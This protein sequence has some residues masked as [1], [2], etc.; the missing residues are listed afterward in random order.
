M[1]KKGFLFIV[2][3][4]CFFI[5]GVVLILGEENS[6]FVIGMSFVVLGIAYSALFA[7]WFKKNNKKNEGGNF[8]S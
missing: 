4:I 2:P 6:L 5:A 7:R 1:L 3:A 8:T